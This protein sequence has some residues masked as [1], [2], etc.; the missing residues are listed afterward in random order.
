MNTDG[1][2][3][4]PHQC[5]LC[6]GDPAACSKRFHLPPD[7]RQIAENRTRLTARHQATFGGVGAIGKQFA[8]NLDATTP[9]GTNELAMRRNDQP[10]SRESLFDEGRINTRQMPV[11]FND[12]IKAA[13]E[14]DMCNRDALSLSQGDERS[15]LR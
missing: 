14:L 4:K 8:P 13:V 9:G 12:V 10:N 11:S 2:S 15:D 5:S 3:V 6:R 1:L 7:L